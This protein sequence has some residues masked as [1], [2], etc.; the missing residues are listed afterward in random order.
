MLPHAGSRQHKEERA[1]LKAVHCGKLNIGEGSFGV[2]GS[3][4]GAQ[5]GQLSLVWCQNGH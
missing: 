5:Q 1:N 2:L 3:K 4:G